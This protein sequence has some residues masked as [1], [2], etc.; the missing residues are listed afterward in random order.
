MKKLVFLLAAVI[1]LSCSNAQK[2]VP[3]A[4]KAG[5]Q[6]Q[7][8]GAEN[9]KWEKENGNYEANFELK[10][11]EYSALLDVSGNT[12]ETEVEIE[13]SDLSATLK[14]YVAKNYPGKKI[15][16]AAKITDAKGVVTYEAEVDGKDLI[17]DN[18][19]NFLKEVKD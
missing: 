7:F 17:F 5:F 16:E 10:E 15:K 1:S 12:V 2:V 4:V 9:V 11:E 13:L 8:P 3:A 6:K 18:S 19:G 14:E